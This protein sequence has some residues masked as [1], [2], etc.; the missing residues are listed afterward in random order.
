[1]ALF[2]RGV[3]D[4]SEESFNAFFRQSKARVVGMI[5]LVTHNYA[6]AED[7]AQEAYSRAYRQWQSVSTK[8][9]PDLWV[10]RVGTRLAID[11]WRKQKGESPLQDDR[12]AEA[13]DVV[14]TMSLRWGLSHL[15]PAQRRVAVLYYAEGLTASEVAKRIGTSEPTVHT[16][17]KRARARLRW[18]LREDGE[19]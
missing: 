12:Q 10:V 5:A 2:A 17:L 16:H 4:A 18:L 15:S 1:M 11:N 7:A 9:R 13:T 6:A 3:A 19:S 14:V 8:D